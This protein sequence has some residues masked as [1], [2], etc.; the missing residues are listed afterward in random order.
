MGTGKQSD[1]DQLLIVPKLMLQETSHT[2]RDN[3]FSQAA[4]SKP[5]W[6]LSVEVMDLYEQAKLKGQKLRLATLLH[7]PEFKQ[8]YLTPIRSLPVSDQCSLLQRVVDMEFSLNDMQREATKLKQQ[9]ALKLAFVKLT[10]VQSWEEAQEEFPHF[11]TEE[12]LSRFMQV[13]VKKNIPKSFTD[14]CHR[15]RNSTEQNCPSGSSFAVEGSVANVVVSQA[16]EISG[17]MIRQIDPAFN[18][19]SL[20]IAQFSESAAREAMENTAY[21]IKEIN[22]F[23]G[24]HQFV[25]AAVCC[26]GNFQQVLPTWKRAF[27]TAEALF[28]ASPPNPGKGMNVCTCVCTPN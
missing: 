4:L 23:F 1:P 8:N 3:I 19:A 5:V 16:A 26:V 14:F 25:A 28:V 11:A 12:Q 6:D 7:K 18:G 20:I 13:D 17:S 27:G 9:L 22:T 21:T 2:H 24:C 15:A 10:N